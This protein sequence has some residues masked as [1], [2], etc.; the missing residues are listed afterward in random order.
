[1]GSKNIPLVVVDETQLRTRVPD[2]LLR[3]E[4]AR[5]KITSECKLLAQLLHKLEPAF[6][7][8]VDQVLNEMRRLLK[9]YRRVT[10]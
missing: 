7:K 2:V 6:A 5:A 1:M 9:Y 10:L 4:S 3:I 8:A